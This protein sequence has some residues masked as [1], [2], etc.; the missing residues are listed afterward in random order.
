[1]EEKQKKMNKEI[2][3]VRTK[4]EHESNSLQ[5]KMQANY[6]EFKRERAIEFDKL[7]QKYKNKLKDLDSIQ[8]LEMGN[9]PKI[10]KGIARPNSRLANMSMSM[11][12]S[13][14]VSNR[15]GK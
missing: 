6:G 7:L 15:V 10:R 14:S 1:V 13:K 8:K 12:M 2:E 3:K 5:M 9:L 4:Q 11:S